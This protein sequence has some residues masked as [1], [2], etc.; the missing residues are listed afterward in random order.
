M[1][2]RRKRAPIIAATAVLSSIALLSACSSSGSGSTSGSA[3]AT[4]ASGAAV[5]VGSGS[6]HP[7]KMKNIALILNDN[8]SATYSVAL[9]N[10]AMATAK[11]DGVTLNLLYDTFA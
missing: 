4:G 1:P 11:K 10:A 8:L 6:I 2:A 3:S 9:V 7:K 5:N